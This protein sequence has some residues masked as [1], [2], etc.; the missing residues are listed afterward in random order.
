VVVAENAVF[1]YETTRRMTGI[2]KMH[3]GLFAAQACYKLPFCGRFENRWLATLTTHIARTI[4]SIAH[5]VAHLKQQAAQVLENEGLLRD[6]AE[7]VI[8]ACHLLTQRVDR[9]ENSVVTSHAVFLCPRPA[10]QQ[11]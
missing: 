11:Q 6:T 1:L 8:A 7:Y 10:S 9:T 2:V 4:C 3:T 5:H